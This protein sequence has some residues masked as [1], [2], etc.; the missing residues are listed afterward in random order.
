MRETERVAVGVDP[1]IPSVARI[2]DYF[3]AGKDNLAADRAAG[4]Q[5]IAMVP[6]IRQV[7]RENRAF[8]GRAV[9]ALSALGIHQFLDI[10]TGLPTRENVHE[11]ALAARSDA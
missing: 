9:R 1:R 8:I 3:L 4:D 10:G 7:A 5:I 11:V 2:Y 6:G